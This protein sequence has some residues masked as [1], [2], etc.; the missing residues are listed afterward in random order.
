MY[1]PYCEQCRRSLLMFE[2]HW[3]NFSR[4]LKNWK[5][6]VVCICKW[7]S[8]YKPSI[9]Y[10]SKCCRCNAPSWKLS[11]PVV[12]KQLSTNF[13]GETVPPEYRIMKTQNKIGLYF[14]ESILKGQNLKE[15]AT[16]VVVNTKN[17]SSKL[18]LNRALIF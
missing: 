17:T 8:K 6:I 10:L 11:R 15:Q 12:L 13:R 4:T 5:L 9:T 1:W 14:R 7:L 2:R 3:T 18:L 16:C